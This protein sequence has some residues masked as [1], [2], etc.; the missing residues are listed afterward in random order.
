MKR[1][2]IPLALVLL[3]A[4]MVTPASFMA[5]ETKVRIDKS[6]LPLEAD[7]INGFIPQ[8]W[9][10][11]A[12]VSGDLNRDSLPDYALKLIEDKP[13]ESGDTHNNRERALLIVLRSKEGK[14]SLAAVADKLLQCTTCGGAFYGFVDA[15]A[16]VSIEKG[17]LV[18]TQ[19]HG[20]RNV[21]EYTYRFRYEPATK[22]FLFIGMDVVD[23]DR[24]T[25]DVV[26]TSANYLT[27]IEITKRFGTG[28]SRTRTSR[29]AV[30]KEKRYL[31]QMDSEQ[32]EGEQ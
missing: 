19:D 1:Y 15:E 24:A 9:K 22:R 29:K 25:G 2:F 23:R 3:L 18:V 26:T 16:N 14:L 30:S 27:G 10:I 13:A 31:E 21:T 17:V 7:N 4:G 20:S 5:Q 12:Q 8:G 32:L 11:E 6:S 28:K